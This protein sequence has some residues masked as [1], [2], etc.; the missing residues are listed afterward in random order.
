[1]KKDPIYIYF[2]LGG[3][4]VIAGLVWGFWVVGSPFEARAERL[5]SQ[6][7][8]DLSN[9]T[10]QLDT[11]LRS[12]GKNKQPFLSRIT[13]DTEACKRNLARSGGVVLAEPLYLALQM[14]GYEGDIALTAAQIEK[15][16]ANLNLEMGDGKDRYNHRLFGCKYNHPF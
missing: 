13:V 6:R 14:Y 7:I 16:I 11:L 2:G 5:D 3:L 10:Y 9:L 1:M 12:G 4:F 15:R 8:N